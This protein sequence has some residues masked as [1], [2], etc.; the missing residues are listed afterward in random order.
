VSQGDFA[1]FAGMLGI[2]AGI[3]SLV[4][5]GYVEV[6]TVPVL[7][8]QVVFHGDPSAGFGLGFLVVGAGFILIPVDI[9][10]AA[11]IGRYVYKRLKEPAP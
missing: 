5:L 1:E 6:Y 8:E 11:M 10:A 3:V 2:M 4:V 7:I 9:W